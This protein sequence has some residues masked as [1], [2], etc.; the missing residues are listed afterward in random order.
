MAQREEEEAKLQRLCVNN[1]GFPGNS[2]TNNMCQSCFQLQSAAAP[3]SASPPRSCSP[4]SAPPA[5]PPA[6][7]KLPEE[8]DPKGEAAAAAAVAAQAPERPANRCF[9]C[10]KRLRLAG[11]RCRCGELFCSQHRYSDRHECSFDYKTAARAI[12]ARENP[13]VRAAKIVRV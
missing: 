8:G 12:I 7:V 5:R 11:F 6:P 1:C 3:A 10:Q 9:S 2:T 13:V 4:R